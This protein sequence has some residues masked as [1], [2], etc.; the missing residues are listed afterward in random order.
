[1]QIFQCWAVKS[2]NLV[3]FAK[4]LAEI[5]LVRYLEA[6]IMLYL[7]CAHHILQSDG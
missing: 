7:V 4:A 3:I 6:F 1:M 5:Y 2:A